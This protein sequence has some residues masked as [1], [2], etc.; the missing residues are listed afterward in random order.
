MTPITGPDGQHIQATAIDAQGQVAGLMWDKSLGT[1]N[2]SQNGGLSTP[3]F[4]QAFVTQGGKPVGLGTLGGTWS[5]GQAINSGAAR[6]CPPPGRRST[7][8][9]T[10]TTRFR[11]TTPS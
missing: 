9:D 11:N 10:S 7:C 2:T 3:T 6:A 5:Q 1:Y 8:P 4:G